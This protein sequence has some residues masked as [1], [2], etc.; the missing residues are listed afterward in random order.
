MA[1]SICS[2]PAIRVEIDVCPAQTRFTRTSVDR[3][4]SRLEG[5]G[6][7]P[8]NTEAEGGGENQSRDRCI[9][10]TF[11]SASFNAAEP[12]V[13]DGLAISAVMTSRIA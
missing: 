13:Q 5:R 12:E 4:L 1:R 2:V 10:F 7:H 6:R 3:R 11:R 9:L 8:W